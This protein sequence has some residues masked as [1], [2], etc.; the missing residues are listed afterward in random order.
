MHPD[1]AEI[2]AQWISVEYRFAVVALIRREKEVKIP[3]PQQPILPSSDLALKVATNIRDITDLLSD[4]PRLAQVLTD[5]AMNEVVQKTLPAATLRGVAEIA[6]EMRY[7]VD[8]S[9]RV[10]LG[11]FIVALGTFEQKKESRLCNGVMKGINC[12]HDTPE[13]RDAISSFFN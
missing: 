1:L 12:Y 11:Q 4:N 6:T 7:K 8:A 9:S 3:T 2:L 5:L 13:L 10:K